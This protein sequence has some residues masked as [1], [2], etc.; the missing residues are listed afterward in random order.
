[1]SNLVMIFRP[2]RPE[3]AVVTCQCLLR[4]N[5]KR[6]ESGRPHNNDHNSRC[7]E[8][9]QRLHHGRVQQ[10]RHSQVD[11]KYVSGRISICGQTDI[12]E[13]PGESVT[14]GKPKVGSDWRFRLDGRGIM[15]ND[16][17]S[18][19]DHLQ[20]TGSYPRNAKLLSTCW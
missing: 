1:M 12:R 8:R 18:L 17:K 2:V 7:R 19:S 10:Y 20:K 16:A 6:A 9:S 14:K 4:K 11:R 5:K 15:V 13:A 3:Q